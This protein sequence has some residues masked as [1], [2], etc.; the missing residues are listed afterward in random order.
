YVAAKVVLGFDLLELKNPVTGITFAYFE[1][2][3]DYITIK[4]PRWDLT[5]FKGASRQLGSTMKSVGEI[6]SI[7]RSFQE[8]I[9]KAVRMVTEVGGGLSALRLQLNSSQEELEQALEAPTDIRFYAVVEA[10]R[11]Q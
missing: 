10:L 3:L 9:Q 6:M 5:K 1:P 2:A 8:A 11:R 4:V 7:G